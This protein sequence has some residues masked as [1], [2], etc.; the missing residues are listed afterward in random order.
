M[1][2]TK[3]I[4]RSAQDD[5]KRTVILNPGGF[6]LLSFVIL[7]PPEALRRGVKNLYAGIEILRS[8]QD[9][10]KRAVILNPPK[11]CAGG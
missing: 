7:N 8:A 1:I 6:A 4:L 9:D 10:L 11:L 2:G 5:L 3:K